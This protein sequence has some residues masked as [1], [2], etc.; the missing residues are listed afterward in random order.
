M[1]KRVKILLGGLAVLGVAVI[2][3]TALISCS[4]NNSSSSTYNSLQ[5]IPT[6]YNTGVNANLYNF[7]NQQVTVPNTTTPTITS[8]QADAT[9]SNFITYLTTNSPQSSISNDWSSVWIAY[10]GSYMA[11]NYNNNNSY[12]SSIFTYFPIYNFA[13]FLQCTQ[14]NG[15]IAKH[16]FLDSFINLVNQQL[17]PA[18]NMTVLSALNTAI[19]QYVQSAINNK[20][21]ND[22]IANSMNVVSYSFDNTTDYLTLDLQYANSTKVQTGLY[23]TNDVYKKTYSK[24]FKPF[25]HQVNKYADAIINIYYNNDNSGGGGDTVIPIPIYYPS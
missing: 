24:T 9:L 6:V 25:Y 22:I 16:T 4:N 10:A 11:Y 8:T 20:L 15:S 1:K 3:C 13:Y 7:Y 5:I 2:S 23:L 18:T 17:I 19:K 14:V 12:W 21:I